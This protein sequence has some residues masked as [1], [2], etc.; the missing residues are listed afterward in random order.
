M[1][2]FKDILPTS[3]LTSMNNTEAY[4]DLITE[5]WIYISYRWQSLKQFDRLY[6]S[7]DSVNEFL[8]NKT[9]KL[10]DW[11]IKTSLKEIRDMYSSSL[12]I[13]WIDKE[14]SA[15]EIYDNDIVWAIL[16]AKWNSGVRKYIKKEIKDWVKYIWTTP[17]LTN[18][19]SPTECNVKLCYKLDDI[20]EELSWT[21]TKIMT[22]DQIAQ[23][24]FDVEDASYLNIT[25][26]PDG[27]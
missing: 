7:K 22:L 19:N 18:M 12:F 5:K 11:R 9:W 13:K 2:Q 10:I 20:I 21:P 27:N 17:L 15:Q 8:K 14:Q 3:K 6:F 16:Y 24:R 26:L 25:D 1:N 23:Q 4:V